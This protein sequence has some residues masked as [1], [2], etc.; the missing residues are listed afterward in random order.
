MKLRDASPLELALRRA[1]VAAL[2]ARRLARWA[3]DDT[4]AAPERVTPT[5]PIA[6][7]L[8][9]PIAR[10]G[11]DAR[12]E[13]GKRHNVKLAATAF[14]GV[15][16]TP[17][18]PLSFWRTLGPATE[19]RGFSW[20]MELRSGCAVPAIGGGIC[21]VSNALFAIA[22]E[23]GWRILERHGHSMA[24]GN[25][26]A[27]DA[28]VAFPHVDL[29]VAPRTG[30]AILDAS[31]R[32]DVLVLV[33][34]HDAPKLRV[35]LDRSQHDDGTTRDTTIRR[36]VWRE[37]ELVEDAVVVD[38]HQRIPAELRTCLDCGQTACHARVTLPEPR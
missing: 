29:V 34:H 22:T 15:A 17:A 19:A 9:I 27:L 30:T 16:I 8:R 2:Q 13:A 38:D 10:A 25:P 32:G 11:A 6:H 14:H 33:V 28:T 3:V 20:G 26:H 23:L 5:G 1:K 7:Q 37:L 31:V 21:L 12:L 36:R 4:F 24:L 18:R 35:E